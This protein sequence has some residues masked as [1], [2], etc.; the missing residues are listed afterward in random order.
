MDVKIFEVLTKGF[1]PAEAVRIFVLFDKVDAAVKASID[2][3]GRFF[4]GKEVRGRA[5][6]VRVTLC[7]RRMRACHPM[8]VLAS[9]R[10]AIGTAAFPRPH[11]ARFGST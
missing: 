5:V 3:R 9:G 11:T 4:G 10:S 6:L 1:D 8:L 7:C 2:L